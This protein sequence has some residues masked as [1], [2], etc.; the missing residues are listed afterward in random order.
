MATSRMAFGRVS[1]E[2]ADRGLRVLAL[3]YRVL[4]PEYTLA[5][6]EADLVLTALV[7]FEDP[8]RPEVSSASGNA[9]TPASESSW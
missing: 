5:T 3:A 7:G 6:A 4:P 8:P 2:M 1:T 9:R